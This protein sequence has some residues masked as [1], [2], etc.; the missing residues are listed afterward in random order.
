[1]PGCCKVLRNE[2]LPDLTL[3]LSRACVL[4]D[5]TC[6][7]RWST[8]ED[9]INYKP[10][11]AR[12]PVLPLPHLLR[13]CTPCALPQ[14]GTAAGFDD[15][16]SFVR[17]GFVAFAAVRPLRLPTNLQRRYYQSFMTPPRSTRARRPSGG[18]AAAAIGVG[19]RK[20]VQ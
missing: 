14:R 5:S 8:R 19:G 4:L 15:N 1:M 20:M 10:I 2:R 11:N 17:W 3:S 18:T 7:L 12:A 6:T 13:R 16:R 9:H